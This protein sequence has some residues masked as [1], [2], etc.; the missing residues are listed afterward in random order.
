MPKQQ[1]QQQRPREFFLQQI[2]VSH[3]R[4]YVSLMI[5]VGEVYSQSFDRT[6]IRIDVKKVWV[7]GG[8]D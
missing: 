1:Q 7:S 5:E 6:G 3:S 8:K 2:T 4:G